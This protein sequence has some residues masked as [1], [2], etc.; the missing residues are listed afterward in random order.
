MLRHRVVKRDIRVARHLHQSLGGLKLRL[1]KIQIG[2]LDW[3]EMSS[4]G[5]QTGLPQKY[6]LRRQ[7][8][9]ISGTKNLGDVD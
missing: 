2:G 4:Q 9:D 1:Q 3:G 7:V 6:I 8:V 5:V